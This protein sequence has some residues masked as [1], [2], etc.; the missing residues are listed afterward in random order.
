MPLH[1]VE[2]GWVA[3]SGSSFGGSWIEYDAD[4]TFLLGSGV[5]RL[6]SVGEEEGTV[7]VGGSVGFGPCFLGEKHG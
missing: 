3:S 4:S 6:E 1:R 2:W 5:G 7:D